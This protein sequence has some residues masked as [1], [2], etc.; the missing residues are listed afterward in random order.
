[1][2]T[3][4]NIDA[5]TKRSEQMYA[6]N[7]ITLERCVCVRASDFNDASAHTHFYCVFFL[8]TARN[9]FRP[10]VML[11]R[12]LE[13]SQSLKAPVTNAII[14]LINCGMEEYSPLSC[15]EKCNM[16]FMYLGK[17]RTTMQKAHS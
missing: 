12:P 15:M 13:M 2:K 11:K 17:S 16:S 10:F 3:P 6:I 5:A 8:P 7:G 14:N 1:M 4:V 9:I